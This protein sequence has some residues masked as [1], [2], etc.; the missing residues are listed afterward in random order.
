[1]RAS[2]F[3]KVKSAP[4]TS[5]PPSNS[6]L[7]TFIHHIIIFTI[8]VTQLLLLLL[9]QVSTFACSKQT[10]HF[11]DPVGLAGTFESIWQLD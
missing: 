2:A 9:L 3:E 10:I 5:Q 8:T 4:K 1:V 11:L 6:S 7:A